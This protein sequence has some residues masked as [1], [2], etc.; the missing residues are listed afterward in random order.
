MG[1]QAQQRG[2]NFVIEPPAFEHSYVV[3]DFHRL[4]QVMVN[5]CSNAIKFTEQGEVRVVLRYL[6]TNANKVN[7]KFSVQDTGAGI[8]PAEQAQLFTRFSQADASVSRRY[9]GT[10]L[11]TKYRLQFSMTDGWRH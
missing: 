7:I 6:S 4:E 9:G 2:L 8:S 11:G 10:G 5:L 3:G 1:E